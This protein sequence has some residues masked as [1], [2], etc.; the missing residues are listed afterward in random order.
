MDMQLTDANITVVSGNAKPVTQFAAMTPLANT[1]QSFAT[2]A[3]NT[4]MGS[5]NMA[6][7]FQL[8]IAAD[9]YA[10]AYTSTVTITAVAGP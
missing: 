4:G 5:Y 6:P 2:A 10:G 7:T 9:A 1:D 3:I 8:G